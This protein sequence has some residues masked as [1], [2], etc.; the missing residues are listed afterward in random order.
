MDF[1]GVAI[2][3][4]KTLDS[5][6][7]KKVDVYDLTSK[8][9]YTKYIIVCTGPNEET[10]LNFMTALENYLIE[11]YSL[12]CFSKEGIHKGNWIILDFVNFVIHIMTEG[13]REKYKIDGMYKGTKKLTL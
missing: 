5:F 1:E 8:D 13:Q 12:S 6:G 3:I 9:T 10:S 2:D 7:A 11:K 4:G